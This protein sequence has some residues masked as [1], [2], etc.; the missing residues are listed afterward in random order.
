MRYFNNKDIDKSMIVTMAFMIVCLV[1]AIIFYSFA[2]D[3]EFYS[4]IG[5]LLLDIGLAL[6]SILF[7]FNKD[8][9]KKRLFKSM[10]FLIIILFLTAVFNFFFEEFGILF[11]FVLF[12]IVGFSINKTDEMIASIRKK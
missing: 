7:Y 9:F 4:K 12:Q 11:M 10:A 6:F 8:S 1:T 2:N 5:D 3:K